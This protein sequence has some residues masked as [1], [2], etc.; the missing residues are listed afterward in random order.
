MT[1]TIEPVAVLG[2]GSWGTALALLLDRNGHRV[3]VWEFNR[4]LADRVRKTREN[5]DFLPGIT[6]PDSIEIVSDLDQ[7]VAGAGCIF[8]AV[9]SHVVREVTKALAPMLDA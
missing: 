8:I 4:K 1:R 9:P 2:G 6:I 5:P 7:A 3:S